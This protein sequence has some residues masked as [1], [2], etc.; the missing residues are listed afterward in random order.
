MKIDI[1]GTV[2]HRSE[3]RFD[4][5]NVEIWAQSNL[6]GLP[7]IS[8]WFEIHDWEMM[9]R[10]YGNFV[11]KLKERFSDG[12]VPV[13]MEYAQA[14]VPGSVEFPFAKLLEY[15]PYDHDHFTSTPAWEMALAIMLMENGRHES[16]SGLGH[17]IGLFGV[18]MA[19]KQEYE[20]Q[21]PGLL[22]WKSE[23]LKRGIAFTLPAAS[24][25]NI[26]TRLYALGED[27]SFVRAI[28][29]AREKITKA[30]GLQSEEITKAT[31]HL[32]KMQGKLDFLDEMETDWRLPPKQARR[33]ELT[34]EFMIEEIKGL[35]LRK[36]QAETSGDALHSAFLDGALTLA[37]SVAQ[38]LKKVP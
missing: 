4:D 3:A 15:F 18:D 7:R 8:R 6:D 22:H 9:K 5:P 19:S 17:E 29:R 30:K 16:C 14:D 10:E 28:T 38:K 26:P 35:G 24:A 37:G 11:S 2:P 36:A 32:A 31:L 27:D 21:R 12:T 1:L 20:S 25:L 23:A 33:G 13:Y 34:W